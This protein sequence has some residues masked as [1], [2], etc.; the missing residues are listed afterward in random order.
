MITI[1]GIVATIVII[2]CAVSLS[3]TMLLPIA[4][5]GAVWYIIKVVLDNVMDTSWMTSG[6][7]IALFIVLLWIII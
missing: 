7:G 1:I 5:A 6:I 3:V 4:I 2:A